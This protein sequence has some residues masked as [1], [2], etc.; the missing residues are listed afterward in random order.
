[1]VEAVEL[2]DGQTIHGCSPPVTS[3]AAPTRTAPPPGAHRALEQRAPS[4][5]GGRH[6]DARP[7]KHQPQR[8]YFWSDQ[9]DDK[10]Q[11]FGRPVVDQP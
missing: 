5:R 6:D 1:V 4:G 8:P 10:L 2:A 11:M 9:Y 7:A 3:P